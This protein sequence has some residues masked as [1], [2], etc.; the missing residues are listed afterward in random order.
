MKN[1]SNETYVNLY[2]NKDNQFEL[3]YKCQ[4]TE[5]FNNDIS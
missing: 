3:Q 4:K 5:D 2:D 1:I